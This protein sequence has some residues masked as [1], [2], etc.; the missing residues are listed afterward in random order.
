[1]TEI[2]ITEDHPVTITEDHPVTITEDHHVLKIGNWYTGKEFNQK[3][4]QLLFRITNFTETHRI[5][6]YRSGLNVDTI[7]FNPTKE[8]QQGGLYFFDQSQI[9]NYKQYVHPDDAYWIRQ[10]EIPDDARVYVEFGKYKADK[11]ILRSRLPIGN[12]Q[13]D[14][15]CNMYAQYIESIKQVYGTDS[16]KFNKECTFF[17]DY[18][19]LPSI[20]ISYDPCFLEYVKEQTDEVCLKVVKQNSWALLYV[21]KQTEAICIEAVKQ[22]GLVLQ[23]VNEQTKAICIEAVKQN[24]LVLQYVNEQT[25]AICIEAVKQNG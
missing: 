19:T 7:P 23:Y 17:L 24:G 3:I 5:I 21:K 8:C 22:N 1:M 2:R 11:F 20:K 10:V 6:Q 25:E 14:K 15:L 12:Y 9:N 18:P 4:N 13:P 16:N